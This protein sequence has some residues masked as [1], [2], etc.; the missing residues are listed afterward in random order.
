MPTQNGAT[1]AFNRGVLSQLALARVDIS[2]YRMAAAVMVNWMPR[3]L[4]S[5]MLRP[6]LAYLGATAS[7]AQAR[8]M[9]FVFSASDT[10]RLEVTQ[11]ETRIWVN[12]VLV[13][14]VAVG[15]TVTNGSFA[16]NLNGWTN[17]SEAGASVT[18]EAASQVNFV[19]TGTTD[20][21][22]DQ[23]LTVASGDQGKRHALRIVITR[24]PIS[25]RVGTS[26]GDDSLVNQTVLNT[27]THS[28][29]F[30]PTG[31]VWIR[32]LSSNQNAT[33]LASCNIE[34][35]GTLTLPTPWQT[36]DLANLRWDQSADVV[37]VGTIGD[38]V[39]PMQFERRA[40]DSWSIVNYMET[41][42]D[43]PFQP[44]NITS[45]TLTASATFGDITLTAS[46][47]VF[48]PGH[49]G[50]L[51]RL[52]SVGQLVTAELAASATFSNPVEVTGVGS[53]RDLTIS[54][55][56]T[57]SGT[58]KLQYSL[59]TP[60]T[61][62]DVTNEGPFTGNG[63]WTYYDGLDNQ[64]VYYRIGFESGGY[65]SGTALIS[66]GISSGSITGVARVTGFVSSTEVNAAVLSDLGGTAATSNWYEGA[67]S[68]QNGWPGTPQLWQGRL[69]WFGTSIFA[70]V[71][72]AY[73]SFDDTITG[74]SAPIIGQ[75]D[76]GPVDNIYWAIGLQQLVVGTAS[77]EI[78]C[79][80]DYLGDAV[81]DENF[82]VMTGSTQGSAN[83]NGL[84]LD[85]SG[86]FVQVSGSRVFSLDLDIYTYSYKSTELSLLVPDFNSAGIAQ[87]AIQR[88]PDTRIHCIRNDGT[89]GVMVWDP[90]ENVQAW[91]EV[92]VGGDGFI[93]D[94]SI[95]PATG[96]AEDQVYYVVRRTVN[97]ATVRYHEK[98]ALESECAGLPVCKTVDSHVVYA[99]AAT[100]NLAAIAPHLV[101]QTVCVWGWNTVNPYVDGNGNEPGLDLGTYVV[102]ADGSVNGLIFEGESYQVTN[103]VVGLAYTA[104]WQSMKQAFAAAMGTPLTQIKRIPRLGLILQNTHAQGIKVGNQFGE[105]MD[106]LPLADL[107]TVGGTLQAATDPTPPTPDVNAL[108]VD[109]DQPMSAFNDVWSTDSRVCLQ[110]ASPRPCTV[111]AFVAELDT[112]G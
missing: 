63:T 99:G 106:D 107:P 102:A 72:D 12:D 54:I 27:G 56:G 41:V 17:S 31:N 43:G 49:V 23:E 29:A 77:A 37:F 45:T 84:R 4:G 59:G 108:L 65:T 67:W 88:K 60:G 92:E 78:S 3:V 70:S 42:L 91:C 112:S 51:F 66:L 7:N 11:N 24:G 98:W 8:T 71:S 58:L 36:T 111:L 20:G 35:A 40:V 87:I 47:A 64:T 15:T 94:V 95:L 83:V 69:W 110:A 39:E 16:A 80:S 62:I 93:E 50:S 73:N 55:G 90:A 44:I 34:A 19:G 52:L 101:G 14:R 13:T 30:T 57:W 96:I 25:L 68:T 2:R 22:L 61:W 74:G 18:W 5:M 21:I 33:M 46:R 104:Q 85:R 100:A 103:A 97:G 79:R 105:Y 82:N 75:F 9:P 81:T 6:G 32:F 10:A 38:T 26:Q 53:Q 28:I 76:S 89:A 48:Y 109:Y 86:V 1:L